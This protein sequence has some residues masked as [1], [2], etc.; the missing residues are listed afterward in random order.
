MARTIVEITAFAASLMLCA[1]GFAS[2]RPC[3]AVDRRGSV[4][5]RAPMFIG[6]DYGAQVP[7]AMVLRPDP[8]V[9][10]GYIKNPEMTSGSLGA[11][12]QGKNPAAGALP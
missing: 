9:Q 7:N 3:H 6:R 11:M 10:Y 4:I 2:A 12:L 5:W 8:T 1:P